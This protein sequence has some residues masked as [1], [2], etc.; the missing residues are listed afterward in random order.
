M[1]VVAIVRRFGERSDGEAERVEQRCDR[2]EDADAGEELPAA[3]PV[4]RVRGEADARDD[5]RQEEAREHEPATDRVEQGCGG[6]APVVER[7]RPEGTE[8]D[9][10]VAGGVVA[11]TLPGSDAEFPFE[12][13]VCRWAERAWP[14]GRERDSAVVVA[15]Q[16]GTQER[17]WDTVVLECDPAALALRGAF[18]DRALSAG[19]L[20]VVRHAPADWAYYR[21]ALPDPGYPWRYVRESIH[22]LSARGALEHRKRSGRIEIRRIAP[23]P[24]W[25]RRVVAIE[26]K[27]DLDKTAARALGA[28][29]E[30][31]VALGLADEAWVATRANDDV[32]ERLLLEG[33]P[34]EA[35]IL[36]VSDA[37]GT[38]VD[39]SSAE[40]VW[41][42]RSLAVDDPGTRI[43]ENPD[44]DVDGAG[45]DAS[46]ARFEYAD[47]AWKRRKRR[48]I[49]ERA[50]ERGW[51]SY[52]DAMRP[53]CRH[54]R[55]E[56]A[57]DGLVPFCDA[58]DRC[59]TSAECRG[60]CGDFEPEPP[61]WRTRGWPIEG[62]PGKGLRRVLDRRHGRFRPTPDD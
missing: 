55:L 60:A 48:E 9:S 36:A 25:V 10:T 12:L 29:L 14:P 21:D 43:V 54:Y 18:G 41:H 51:R 40:V 7:V 23:Y 38:D 5:E 27:P 44:P 17:R 33:L 62:G 2:E 42:P 22:A 3:V 8:R 4:D 34:V 50:Y 52:V 53:D 19:Q 16:L 57:G 59:Q 37:V 15:R 30:T 24:D 31:D 11:V 6:H 61:A 47:V 20:H 26:N 39:R 46:A 45:F 56:P 58:K 28:Q 32:N 13:A 49:A 1:L 35:G